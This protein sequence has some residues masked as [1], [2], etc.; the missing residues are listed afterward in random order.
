MEQ[1]GMS[2]VPVAA[3]QPYPPVRAQ[4]RNPQYARAILSN[5][6]GNNSEMS[7]VGQYVYAQLVTEGVPEVA[8][9]LRQISMEE[10]HHLKIFGTLAQQLGADPRL[11][12]V[13]KGRHVWW[14]PEWLTY[15]RRLGPLLY[16][17][18]QTEQASVRKY[19]SQC[20]WIRDSNVVENLQRI[21]QDEESHIEIL[22]CLREKYAHAGR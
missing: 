16:G 3:A 13:W 18:I 5:L 12:S 19:R 1:A 20:L 8:E 21:L 15:Q 22:T 6:G 17:A 7:A 10:M 14:T 9:A 4:G 11:W 2:R